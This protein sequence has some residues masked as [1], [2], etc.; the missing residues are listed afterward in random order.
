MSWNGSL[1]GYR[2]LVPLAG[3]LKQ[4][5]P[6]FQMDPVRFFCF[7]NYMAGFQSEAAQQ[8]WAAVLLH[9]CLTSAG[10]E[11]FPPPNIGLTENCRALWQ[12]L[13]PRDKQCAEVA[14]PPK[15]ALLLPSLN[16]VLASDAELV[17]AKWAF[18]SEPP[19]CVC[20][21]CGSLAARVSFGWPL[22]ER[23][24]W[25]PSGSAGSVPRALTQELPPL[26]SAGALRGVSKAQSRCSQSSPGGDERWKEAKPRWGKVF[27]FDQAVTVTGSQL[28]LFM[29]PENLNQKAC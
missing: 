8:T 25:R 14:N 4:A 16:F 21:G 10:S 13:K 3:L 20:C 15:W 9:R 27:R 29:G 18:Y 23:R 2:L 17:N 26:P 5:L 6:A 28:C 24:W 22:W 19:W 7:W 12:A 1:H 11:L